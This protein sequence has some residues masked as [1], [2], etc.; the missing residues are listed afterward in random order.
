MLSEGV[1]AFEAE[2][3]GYFRKPDWNRIV[4]LFA[5]ENVDEHWRAQT[6]LTLP[7]FLALMLDNA[8]EAASALVEAVRA[9]DPVKI[10]VVAQALNYSNHADRRRLMER[11]VG[12]SAAAAMDEAGAD[13]KLLVPSH[14]VHVDMLWAAFFA[15]G[16][17][18]YLTRIAELLAGWMPEA[19]LKPL[20]AVAAKDQD[21]ASKAMPAVVAEAAL[22]SL[23]ANVRDV[24]EVRDALIAHALKQDGLGSALAAR[25]VA[26]VG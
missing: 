21:A 24:E 20:L 3:M 4:T 7:V 19:Q 12:E 25:I 8:P 15:T 22:L 13:F 10:E 2:V 14:P 6:V 17:A 26:G 1:S 18:D 23:A 5:A 11:V 9:G 16:D